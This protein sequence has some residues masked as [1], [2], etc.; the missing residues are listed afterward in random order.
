M[1]QPENE[2]RLR[3]WFLEVRFVGVMQ[4]TAASAQFQKSAAPAMTAGEMRI[5]NMMKVEDFVQSGVEVRRVPLDAADCSEIV[6]AGIE[7]VPPLG[8]MFQANG[9]APCNRRQ[10]IFRDTSG[11]S[12]LLVHQPV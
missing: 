11:N 8:K 6:V 1:T 10:W 5:P 4:K 9:R 2:G 12:E 7:T 3:Y